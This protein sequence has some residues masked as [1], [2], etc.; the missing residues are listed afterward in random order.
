RVARIQP[1]RRRRRSAGNGRRRMAPMWDQRG[2]PF[3]RVS[4]GDLDGLARIDI[5]AYELNWPVDV[6]VTKSV[7]LLAD[8]VPADALIGNEGQSVVFTVTASNAADSRPPATGVSVVDELPAG[9]TFVSAEMTAG[10]Y[11]AGVWSGFDLQPGE[12]EVLRIEAVIDEATAGQV[13]ANTAT[14]SANEFDPDLTNNEDSASLEINS[15]DLSVA[16]S[17]D[18]ETPNVDEQ[19]VYVISASNSV[20]SNNVATGVQ[21]SD[22][23]PEG[24]TIVSAET[25]EGEFSDGVWSGLELEPGETQTLTIT[26]DLLQTAPG[27][28]I[29]NRAVISGNQTDP[30]SANNDDSASLTVNSVDLVVQKSVDDD[31][32]DNDQQAVYTILAANSDASNNLATGVQVIDS[33]PEGL[34]IVSAETTEGEYSDGV[35][36]GLE[37]EPGESQTLTIT[38]D[39]L[40]TPPGTTIDNTAAISG[41]QTDPNLANNEDSASLTVS[42]V[43]LVV[44]KL[45]DDETPN[46]DQQVVYTIFASNADAS[47]NTATGVQVTDGLPPSLTLLSVETTEGIYSEGVWSGLELEP[48]E[49][50]T[51][52]IIVQLNEVAPG[53]SLTN[54]AT[55]SGNEA[56]PDPSNNDSAATLTV[57]S[58]DL[59]ISKSADSDSVFVGESVV[60]SVTATNSAASNVP[61][62]GVAVVDMLPDALS[63]LSAEPTEGDYDDGLWSGFELAPGETQTLVITAVVDFLPSGATLSNAATITGDQTDPDLSN[64]VDEALVSVDVIVPI[65]A[66]P[67][68]V[69]MGNSLMRGDFN[70]DGVVDGRDIDDSEFGFAG[71]FGDDLSGADFLTWQRNLGFTT[72]GA[73]R[74]DSTSGGSDVVI[75]AATNAAALATQLPF[76][77]AMVAAA[78]SSIL[79][80]G[81][82]SALLDDAFLAFASGHG[83]SSPIDR[84]ASSTLSAS[85]SNAV[86]QR[87]SDWRP[88]ARSAAESVGDQ[89]R[90]EEVSRELRDEA[91]D[92]A[93]VNGLFS[94]P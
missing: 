58:V 93:F 39:L 47:N 20:A 57:N 75:P 44:Q 94:R 19:V 25:T 79:T 1:S 33:L 88:P 6:F 66:A 51:L 15:V 34:T 38:V 73:T 41:D 71:R 4:D 7:I 28:T 76:R 78:A 86:D 61:A 46:V 56:D 26:V 10:S 43:D 52:E 82:Q 17:I 30:N 9:L 63:V 84:L 8:G 16:K 53:G 31:T 23:L 45:V 55:I 92:S 65:A 54:T 74:L 64:N 77:E 72:R 24:L 80:E 27:A 85:A 29:E 70:A 69:P 5:G 68:V 18:D 32:P 59:V 14:I 21:V 35:W 3:H 89:P 22:G 40:Q 48:G 37:L 12:T 67:L 36:S 83:D 11:E 60:F 81:R 2:A 49:T 42:S 87:S 62:T 50:E 13:L 90:H 91:F